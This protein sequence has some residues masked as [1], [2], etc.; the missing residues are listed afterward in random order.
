MLGFQMTPPGSWCLELPA[1]LRRRYEAFELLGES[2][3]SQKNEMYLAHNL[4]PICLLLS[5]HHIM[6]FRLMLSVSSASSY[7]V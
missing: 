3:L 6:Y 5:R 7:S 2:A 4:A 1:A